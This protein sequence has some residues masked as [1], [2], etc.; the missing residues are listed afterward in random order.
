MA[1]ILVF[2]TYTWTVADAYRQIIQQVYFRTTDIKRGTLSIAW[3]D[4]NGRFQATWAHGTDT[5]YG[6]VHFMRSDVDS[7][8]VMWV[9]S[10]R[11]MNFTAQWWDD[12]DSVNGLAL[13][14]LYWPAHGALVDLFSAIGVTVAD[15]EYTVAAGPNDFTRFGIATQNWLLRDDR[16]MVA[17][18]VAF[19]DMRAWLRVDNT[20]PGGRGSDLTTVV[21]AN[22]QPVVNITNF[23]QDADFSVN[24]GSAIYSVQGKVFTET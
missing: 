2:E 16:D 4:T 17:F 11:G 9:Q 12:T 1:T 10:I 22:T 3:D 7:P 13:L 6:L 23:Q 20:G 5:W 19:I 24:R 15:F 21:G 18:S 8:P 14:D